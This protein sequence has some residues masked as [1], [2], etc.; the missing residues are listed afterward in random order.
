MKWLKIKPRKKPIPSDLV[1]YPF[2]SVTLEKS[3]ETPYGTRPQSE[4]TQP[5]GKG[6]YP[7]ETT[8][9]SIRNK[10]DSAWSLIHEKFLGQ[11]SVDYPSVWGEGKVTG[12]QKSW[13][14]KS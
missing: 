12:Q 9:P 2:G 11:R 8:S 4:V 5:E 14:R 7:Y 10:D 3:H 1:R 6:F 13:L